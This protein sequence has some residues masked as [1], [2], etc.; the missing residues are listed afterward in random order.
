MDRAERGPLCDAV[1]KGQL[2]WSGLAQLPDVCQPLDE[3]ATP[4]QAA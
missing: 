4:S 3:L 1:P 2:K